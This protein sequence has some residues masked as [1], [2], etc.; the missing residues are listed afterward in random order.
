MTYDPIDT[1]TRSG[2]PR[3]PVRWRAR[4]V[5]PIACRSAGTRSAG[6]GRSDAALPRGCS[7]Y[8]CVVSTESIATIAVQRTDKPW[9]DRLRRYA[10]VIDGTVAGNLRRG[11]SVEVP[12]PAGRHEV[13]LKIDWCS[14]PSVAVDV[15]PAGRADLAGE[16]IGGFRAFIAM[17]IQPHSYLRLWQ[18][19]S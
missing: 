4:E 5:M 13:R 7:D 15:M 2:R 10:V 3:K 14:S 11:E 18:V 6:T 9:P 12:V 16:S 19:A 8:R 1:P 17:V